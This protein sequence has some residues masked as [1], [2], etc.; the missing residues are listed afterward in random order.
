MR[1]CLHILSGWREDKGKVDGKAVEADE[2][3]AILRSYSQ[4]RLMAIMAVMT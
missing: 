4:E 1:S 2:V 3:P